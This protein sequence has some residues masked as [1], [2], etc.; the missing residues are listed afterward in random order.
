MASSHICRAP[1]QWICSWHD[2][3]SC[4]STTN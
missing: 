3:Q 4:W 2:V 1:K